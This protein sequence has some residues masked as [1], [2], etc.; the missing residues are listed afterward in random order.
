MIGRI[1]ACSVDALNTILRDD[2]QKARQSDR[3]FL[4]L[5][6]APMEALGICT[7]CG[8]V[9]AFAAGRGRR[10]KH[11]CWRCGSEMCRRSSRSGEKVA[12]RLARVNASFGYSAERPLCAGGCDRPALDAH[13]TCGAAEC[14]KRIPAAPASLVGDEVTRRRRGGR[15]GAD[16][17]VIVIA[18]GAIP[19][20]DDA[21]GLN[22]ESADRSETGA[23][24]LAITVAGE[25]GRA[26]E[27]P[28]EQDKLLRS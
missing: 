13:L 4:Q 8:A 11:A 26:A 16:G 28:P 27:P 15:R 12:A 14:A 5:L 1:A 24:A 22:R 19:Q 25:V 10:R 20:G 23:E 17:K 6:G 9:Q 2:A 7:R 18:H 21:G 3:C